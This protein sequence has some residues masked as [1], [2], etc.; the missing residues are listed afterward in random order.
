V[1]PPSNHQAR[2]KPWLRVEPA[3][4]RAAFF[5]SGWENIHGIAEVERGERWAMTAVFTLGNPEPSTSPDSATFSHCTHPSDA[6]AYSFCR[7]G[8]STLF[9]YSM[10]PGEGRT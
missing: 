7:A 5:S 1:N 8:W 4:G 3:A 6:M 10:E 9:G 2:T